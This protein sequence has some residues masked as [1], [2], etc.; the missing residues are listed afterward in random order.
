MA[1][2]LTNTTA[3]SY[4]VSLAYPIITLLMA[5]PMLAVAK[6]ARNQHRVAFLSMLGPPVYCVCH[7]PTLVLH[8][9]GPPA[10]MLGPPVYC[11]CHGP[12]LVLHTTGPPAQSVSIINL[13]P[14]AYM[15]VA[16]TWVKPLLASNQPIHI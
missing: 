7:G 8:T 3:R 4:L 5:Y 15:I 12:T 16:F 1:K 9:T 11:V 2:I 10:Q 14:V 6:P 13:L